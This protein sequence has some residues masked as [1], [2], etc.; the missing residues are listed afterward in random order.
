[1]LQK[2][3]FTRPAEITDF[4]EKFRTENIPIFLIQNRQSITS[5]RYQY[6][7]WMLEC[8]ID[9]NPFFVTKIFFGEKNLVRKNM[10]Q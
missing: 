3:Q 2:S 10:E 8:Y 7:K 4:P 1:M 5:V 6:V 9:H